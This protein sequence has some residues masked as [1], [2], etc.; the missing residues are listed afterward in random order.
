MTEQGSAP[1]VVLVHG[2]WHQPWHWHEVEDR[3]TARGRQVVTVDLPSCGP[4]RGDLYDDSAAIR[5]ALDRQSDAVLVAHSYGGIPATDAAVD[6]PAVR[7]IVY[8]SAY[9]ADVGESLGGFEP[10]A[11]EP[12]IHP[13][14]DLEM[15]DERTM[16]MKPDRALEVLFHDCPD[17]DAAV[18]H[19]RGMNPVVLGQSP[20]SVAWRGIPA[21]YVVT[22]DDRATAVSVQRE[23]SHRADAVAEIPSGHSSFLARPDDV[24]R[25]VEDAVATAYS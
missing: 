2:A 6:H 24:C 13:Q 8:L 19:L 25:I 20:R 16:A 15:V 7:R 18:D 23:L 3:L 1:T 5:A 12:N 9:M 21:T 17:A 4:E 14:T 11:T 22:T 10:P